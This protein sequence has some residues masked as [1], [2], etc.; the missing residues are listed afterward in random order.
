[1]LFLHGKVIK[2]DGIG[3]TI[4]YPTANININKS[5]KII[6][7]DGVYTIQVIIKN[8]T[9]Y[10][11]LNIGYRPTVNGKNRRFE[12]HIFDFKSKIYDEKIKI[13]NLLSEQNAEIIDLKFNL[14]NILND[15]KMLS[16]E[17]IE[18][19]N[20]IKSLKNKIT[21]KNKTLND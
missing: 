6:P 14:N 15:K 11:M 4:D 7:K 13:E 5:K 18:L 3:S 2:G 16:N 9:Y 19:E 1:M 12:V 10:G 20:T 8:K 21:I 17:I